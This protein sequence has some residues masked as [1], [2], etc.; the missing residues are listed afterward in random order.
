MKSAKAVLGKHGQVTSIINSP[1]LDPHSYEPT[2]Q[3]AKK[4]AQ[5]DVVIENGL[6]YDQWL[7]KVAASSDSDQQ[8]MIT[9]NKLM[10]RTDGDNEHLWY[11]LET[12]PTLT[13]QLIT[14]FSKIDPST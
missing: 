3:D 12:M 8:T 14:R 1:S 9:V 11:D 5:A 2:T 7:S 10:K 4:V 6:G 13:K